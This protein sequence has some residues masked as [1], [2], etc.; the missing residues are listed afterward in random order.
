MLCG[1]VV[2]A[3]EPVVRAVGQG[4]NFRQVHQAGVRLVNIVR[5]GFRSRV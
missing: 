2:T 5:S 3:I 1:S 4:A